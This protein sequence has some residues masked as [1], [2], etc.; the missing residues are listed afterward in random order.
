MLPAFPAPE[1]ADPDGLLAAGGDLSNERLL[2][3]YSKGIFPWYN[4]GEPI[5]WWCPDPRMVLFPKDLKVSASMRSILRKGIFTY[6]MDQSFDEVIEACARSSAKSGGT[7]LHPEMISAYKALHASGHAHSVEVWQQSELVGGLY[8]V[9]IGKVFFG[10][11][12]F[13][14]VTNASKAGF[15]KFTQWA[16]SNGMLM[17]DCQISSAHLHSLGA[18]EIPRKRFLHLLTKSDP[19]PFD[20]PPNFE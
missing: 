3:A 4:E 18:I 13:H 11:S 20:F 19:S 10:E 2:L 17:I 5:L 9:A 16:G 6:S 14:S 7:W 1:Q 15:I 8:G 12:M